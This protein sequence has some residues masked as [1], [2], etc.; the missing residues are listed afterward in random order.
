[1]ITQVLVEDDRAVKGWT[2]LQDE[3]NGLVLASETF[4][5]SSMTLKR[6]QAS[7]PYLPGTYTT[8]AL[9]DNIKEQIGVYIYED[10]AGTMVRKTDYLIEL[11]VR[12]S[13]EMIVRYGDGY[14]VSMTAQA[15]DYT[16][17]TQREYQ[18]AGVTKVVFDVPF[19]P[20]TREVP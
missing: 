8:R 6:T 15:S 11:F 1:M 5:T 17:T 2:A 12:P 10:D 19:L 20:I 13:F 4:S 14:G 3:R 7:N 9:K 18:H 16:R